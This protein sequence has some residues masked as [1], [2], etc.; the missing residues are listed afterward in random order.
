MKVF[1]IYN[2][3]NK[4]IVA[5]PTRE[6]TEEYGRVFLG[7][8]K[9]W[10][11]SIREVYLHETPFP[12]NI[13]PVTPIPFAPEKPPYPPNIWCGDGTVPK[14]TYDNGPFAPGTK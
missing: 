6:E 13:T 1:A 3:S 14:A 8:D 10:E 4:F 12:L 5:L 9:G 11:Y 2:K 7:S